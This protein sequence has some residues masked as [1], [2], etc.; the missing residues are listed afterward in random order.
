M[1]QTYVLWHLK[2]IC[3]EKY[4]IS[5]SEIGLF[6]FIHSIP[7]STIVMCSVY[8]SGTMPGIKYSLINKTNIVLPIKEHTADTKIL[9]MIRTTR[10][11]IKKNY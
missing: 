2:R 8:I 3:W 9:I 1:I 10:T 7:F 6:L 4:I 5:I 11:K